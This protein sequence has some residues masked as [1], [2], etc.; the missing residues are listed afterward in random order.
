MPG[1]A[2]QPQSG[3]KKT[4]D[5]PPIP[6]NNNFCNIL[7]PSAP[8]LALYNNII[9]S[10]LFDDIGTSRD[11]SVQSLR[12]TR[13]MEH[14]FHSDKGGVL[15]NGFNPFLTTLVYTYMGISELH[16]L[17][18]KSMT[19]ETPPPIREPSDDIIRAGRRSSMP[20]CVIGWYSGGMWRTSVLHG[21]IGC[22]TPHR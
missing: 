22:R 3:N 21:N 1:I 17:T 2:A 15:R 7:Y 19:A 6:K 8:I 14:N 13:G 18:G 16:T 11:Y 9:L 20:D 5:A 10:L 12:T 4:T